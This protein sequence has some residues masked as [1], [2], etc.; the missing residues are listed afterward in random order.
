[1]IARSKMTSQGLNREKI[2]D[3]LLH[4]VKGKVVIVGIGNILKGDD[5]FGPALIEE[6][7]GSV[8]AVCIDTGSAPENY[9]GKIIKE[10]PGI[11]II[12]DAAHLGLAPGEYDLLKKDEIARSGLTTHDLSP[13][14]FIDHL[15]E[16]I[17]ADIYMLAVQPENVS[18]GEEMSSS[19]KKAIDELAATIKE[20]FHA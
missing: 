8:N 15:E 16:G 5:G 2:S 4:T 13:S 6:I 9:I 17:E 14:M 10:E 18:F 19:I 1:M 3:F 11:V 20:T 12:I 7:K